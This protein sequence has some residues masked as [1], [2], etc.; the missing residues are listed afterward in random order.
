MDDEQRQSECRAAAAQIVAD[1]VAAC[2]RLSPREREV[3]T[4]SAKG[5]TTNEI[6]DLLGI[7]DA[8]VKARRKMIH[9]KLDV[10]TVIEAA[11]IAAKAGIV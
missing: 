1:A 10:Q 7:G 9:R 8:T 11:V 4:L 3:L 5:L 2:G 6:A